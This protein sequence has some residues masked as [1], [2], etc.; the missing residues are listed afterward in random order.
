[1]FLIFTTFLSNCSF[2]FKEQS[3]NIPNQP[4][5]IENMLIQIYFYY[6][7]IIVQILVLRLNIIH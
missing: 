2:I 4:K 3:M 5:L 6:E 1:M 7:I